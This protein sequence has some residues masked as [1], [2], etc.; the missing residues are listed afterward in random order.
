VPAVSETIAYDGF[1]V[2]APLLTH[3]NDFGGFTEG[4][5]EY[6]IVLHGDDDTPL[7]WVNVICNE[8]F[9]TVVG[10]TGASWTWAVNSRENRLTPFGNDT[11]GEWS[12]EALY[13][14]DEDDG[15]VWGA[16]P[17]PLPRGDRSRWVTT[18]RGVT[19]YTSGHHGISSQLTVFVHAEEPLKISRLVLT[20]H[21]GNRRRLS[22]FAYHEWALCP[23]RAGDH[24]FVVT[25][26]DDATGAVLARNPHNQ[27]FGDR[28]AFAH[29]TPGAASSTGDSME[30]LG[31]NGSL[32]RP[33]A[34]GRESLA[35]VFG[36]GLD[37]CAAL[38]VRID[39]EPGETREVIVLLGQGDDRAHALDLVRRFGDLAS[40]SAALHEVERRWDRCWT[41]RGLHSG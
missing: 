2:E 7:P 15:E 41:R 34:L 24:R 27:P 10:A 37:P 35:G 11:V 18:R 20:N 22:L 6:A 5:R 33:A 31:R 25:E 17:G 21:T 32:R 38:Q 29:A 36:A 8:R 14:R 19:R 3:A 1:E 40:V 39:L 13:L 28:V 26:R 23:P 30:F 9:G 4:G 16:T 12:G